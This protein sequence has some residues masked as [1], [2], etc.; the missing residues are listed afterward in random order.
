MESL[1]FLILRI[2][3]GITFCLTGYYILSDKTHWTGMI[4][5]WVR[6]VLP[7]DPARLMIVVGIYDIFNG[8]WLLAGIYVWLAALLAALHL[9]QVLIAV[10][11]T[12]V[13]YRDIGLLCAS[14]ALTLASWPLDIFHKLLP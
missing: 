14:I 13:T 6:K 12:D 11:V 2:G 7:I 9:I 4:S 5:P 8:L 1:A 10:G 3:L